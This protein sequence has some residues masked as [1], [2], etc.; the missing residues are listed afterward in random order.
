MDI[1]IASNA[2][3][4][5]FFH[6]F[7]YHEVAV[8]GTT[9]TTLAIGV[10]IA[11]SMSDVTF[12]FGP[13]LAVCIFGILGP[14]LSYRVYLARKEIEEAV[15]RK[16]ERAKIIASRTAVLRGIDES[17]ID[18][19]AE[20]HG[21]S[22]LDE[23][24]SGSADSRNN[25]NNTDETNNN[26]NNNNAD[27]SEQ[28]E[29]QDESLS[30]CKLTWNACKQVFFARVDSFWMFLAGLLMAGVGALFMLWDYLAFQTIQAVVYY[31]T[32]SAS[33]I[34]AMINDTSGLST[35]FDEKGK[36]MFMLL[37]GYPC[38]YSSTGRAWCPVDDDLSYEI[39]E[40]CDSETGTIAVPYPPE[41]LTEYA[42][43]LKSPSVNR[44]SVPHGIW[45]LFSMLAPLVIFLATQP[46]KGNIFF[47]QRRSEAQKQK[48]LTWIGDPTELWE[49]WREWR[50][51]RKASKSLSVASRSSSFATVSQ[52]NN[53]ELVL[54]S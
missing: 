42:Y 16:N 11:Q 23:V 17:A 49:Q 22:S 40:L 46:R 52:G 34:E 41:Q 9:M 7:F 25:A 44:Y 53:I 48:G 29:N 43:A 45:H 32:V 8:I 36:T 47:G 14:V 28:E 21:E 33:Y 50:A 6:V 13:L 15:E 54:P 26:E 5:T 39:F 38:W 2:L 3:C 31:N 30:G 18:M 4:M 1:I 19:G 24:G 37:N 35:M 20:G 12:V 27:T 10:V 51:A